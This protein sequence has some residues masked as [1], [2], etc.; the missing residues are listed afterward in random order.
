MKKELEELQAKILELENSMNE[1]RYDAKQIVTSEFK[2]TFSV[3][4]QRETMFPLHTALVVDTVDPWKQNRV[5]FFSP[6]LHKPDVPIQSLPFAEAISPM[7]GFDDCG[8]TWIPPAGSTLCVFFENGSR[9]SPYYIG[10][11]WHRNRGPDGQH[12]WGYPIE[13]YY[14]L[15]EGHRGGY[16]VGPNDGSQVFPPWNTENYNGLDIDSIAD[17]EN[18]LDAQN[19]ITN[20]N[21]YGMKTPQKHSIKMVDGDYNCT[22]RWKRFEMSSSTGNWIMMK[23]DHIRPS[24][25]WANPNCGCGGGDVSE[26]PAEEIDLQDSISPNDK[27]KCANPYHKQESECRPFRGPQTPQNNRCE[28]HQSGIQFVSVG[29]HSFFMDDSVEQPT[30]IPEWERG[31]R[32]FDF[33]STDKCE[34]KTAWI[35]MTGHKIEMS[36]V[37]DQPKQ[38]G[39]NNYIRII[40]ACGNSLE[41]NDHTI[42]SCDDEQIAGNKRGW[43]L[44]STSNH[45][46]ELKDEGNEQGSSCRREGGIPESRAKNGYIRIRTGY[47]LNFEMRDSFSQENTE[48]QTISLTAPQRDNEDRGPHHLMFQESPEGPG[49]VYMQVGGNYITSTYD[50]HLELVGDIDF[51]PS[52]KIRMVS[53]NT[54]N[55]TENFYFNIAKTHLFLAKERIFLAAGSELDPRCKDI[56][57]DCGPCIHPV[58]CMTSRGI[59]ISDRV[60]AAASPSAPIASIFQLI[61]FVSGESGESC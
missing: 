29:G 14:Q 36:D 7:G 26:C 40:T 44:R 55:M 21:I 10:T 39:E 35:S 47:G 18:D 53:D 33:G 1:L 20:P 4:K 25:Q 5:R 51:N 37:E 11:T 46:I 32:S 61:P 58:L 60:Y 12:N 31:A 30:G 13:E 41:A 15:H 50:N 57:G 28:L 45:T 24:G 52:N 54:V 59:A 6:F 43:T 38:R 34:G 16:M 23:D 22:H 19:K 48:R 17:F 27:P 49:L 2:N 3:K 42:N 8:L 56:N 9:S